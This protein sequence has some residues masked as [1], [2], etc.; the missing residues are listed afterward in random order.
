MYGGWGIG[1]SKTAKFHVV[2]S[3]WC[4]WKYDIKDTCHCIGASLCVQLCECAY[5]VLQVSGRS[6]GTAVCVFVRILCS[7]PH[8]TQGPPSIGSI[9]SRKRGKLDILVCM[10]PP[11]GAVSRRQLNRMNSLSRD[12]EKNRV[13]NNSL[14]GKLKTLTICSL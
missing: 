2:V 7:H 14:E 4:A 6:V 3:L 10:L 11:W 5:L 1:T 8:S 9:S 13:L 12:K